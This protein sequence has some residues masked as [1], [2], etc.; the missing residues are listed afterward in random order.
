MSD[1]ISSLFLITNL[2]LPGSKFGVEFEG[3]GPSGFVP[4]PA[5]QKSNGSGRSLID[6]VRSGK[7]DAKI[8]N[9]EGR[10]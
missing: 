1:D 2:F 9:D 7:V 5:S 10:A 4:V 6:C 8:N 3:H